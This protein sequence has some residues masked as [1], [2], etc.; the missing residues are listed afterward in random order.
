[1]KKIL[2]TLAFL[3]FVFIPIKAQAQ[4]YP[5]YA[6]VGLLAARPTFCPLTGQLYYATDTTTLYYATV[7]GTSCTWAAISGGGGGGTVTSVT[8]TANQVSV[9]TGTTT[10]VISL[11]SAIIFPGTIADAT[12]G[13][14]AAPSV[15]SF[16]G[17]PY[18]AGSGSTNLPFFYFN[19]GASANDWS[20]GGTIFG[21]NA[22][23]GFNGDYLAFRGNGNAR[24]FRVD[25]S[26]DVFAGGLGSF[27]STLNAGT[28]YEI[29]GAAPNGHCLLGNGTNYVDSSSCN[30]SSATV[31][32]IATTAPLGGGT[33][34]TTGTLTCSTC[35]TNASALTSNV[36][37]K[38]SGGQATQTSSITDN[39]TTV[40]TT[41]TGGYV[42]PVFTANGTTA[43][44]ADYPQGSTSAAVAPCNT[45]TS[46][47]EQA[48]TAV[49][50]YLVNK[51]GV[52]ANGTLINNNASAV[53]T[54]GFSGDA[55]HSAAVTTGSGTS[56][57]STQL[58]SSAN[59]PAGTYR[60][61]TYIDVTTACGTTGT[62]AVNLIYT[63]DQGSKT[64][65][66]NLNGTGSVPATGLLTTTSTANF[67]QESQILRLTSG[68]IN[69]STTAVS[70]GTAGPMVGHLYLSVEP[71]Q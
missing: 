38:G 7:A 4:T 51:P 33:I 45:A 49:T 3:A 53:I 55:N 64:A 24:N 61:N 68:S 34:T 37:V 47:C 70:C 59:C 48:P 30:T 15:A 41:D 52:A 17:S 32:S 26:G 71:V 29:G 46:I 31:S 40:T 35:T 56:I 63:D 43:G 1:M 27:G 25:A 9:A 67:G 23:S 11:P 66:V 5:A 12:S 6:N 65:V 50:S 57:G 20:G 58:C 42:A 28:G 18:T 2:R 14:L 19:G 22:P 44:F 62:Y 39:A 16:T 8:G 60:V 69:Y 36:L 54:Q 13:T 21:I 10:P